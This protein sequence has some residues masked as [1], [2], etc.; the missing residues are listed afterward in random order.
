[1]LDFYD[2]LLPYIIICFICFIICI[3]LIFILGACVLYDCWKFIKLFYLFV[4]SFIILLFEH[5]FVVS[6][7]K[8]VWLAVLPGWIF[9]PLISECNFSLEKQWDNWPIFLKTYDCMTKY[10]TKGMLNPTQATYWYFVYLG[11]A[12]YS[13]AKLFERLTLK[14]FVIFWKQLTI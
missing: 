4:L 13:H 8:L 11:Y 10:V 9:N 3:F 2:S 12:L 14:S 7:T 1:M 5:S 6:I